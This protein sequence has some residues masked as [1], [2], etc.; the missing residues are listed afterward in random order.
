V[1]ELGPF[2]AAIEGDDTELRAEAGPDAMINIARD[3]SSVLVVRP[4][5]EGKQSGTVAVLHEGGGST[6]ARFG[7]PRSFRVTAVDRDGAEFVLTADDGRT[8]H[9]TPDQFAAEPLLIGEEHNPR[10]AEQR[11]QIFYERHLL[12]LNRFS[13]PAESPTTDRALADEDVVAEAGE[14]VVTIGDDELWLSFECAGPGKV[15]QLLPHARELLADIERIGRDGAEFMWARIAEDDETGKD[16]DEF[17]DVA[18]P[19]SLVI[20]VSG[21]F[22]VHYEETSEVYVMDG[23]WLAVQFTAD[24]T[25]VIHYVDA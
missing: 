15:R 22:A 10:Y 4:T 17:L 5:T 19:T 9:G 12:P 1:R 6:L 2:T 16:Q 20:Y 25:P 7:V 24:R 13:S 8:V 23:Y 21:D 14:V 11:E 3:L 18:R